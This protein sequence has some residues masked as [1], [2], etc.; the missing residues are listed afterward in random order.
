MP[1][2]QPSDRCK[3]QSPKDAQPSSKALKQ[4]DD[5]RSSGPEEL[6]HF[7]QLVEVFLG[8]DIIFPILSVLEIQLR[9]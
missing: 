1:L 2:F 8:L 6:D 5:S 9:R 7:I 3:C 4:P